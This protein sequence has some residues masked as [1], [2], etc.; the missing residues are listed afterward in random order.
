[1]KWRFFANNGIRLAVYVA[2]RLHHEYW[3]EEIAA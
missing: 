2:A 3:R 1:V